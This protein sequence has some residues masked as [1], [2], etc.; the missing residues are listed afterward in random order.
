MSIYPRS[1][2][3]RLIRAEGLAVQARAANGIKYQIHNTLADGASLN[4]VAV[5][6]LLILTAAAFSDTKCAVTFT[7]LKIPEPPHK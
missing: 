2:L 5:L 7:A 4:G 3:R 6:L 1:L